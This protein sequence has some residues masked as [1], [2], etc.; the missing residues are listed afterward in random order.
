MK[1]IILLIILFGSFSANGQIVL[2]DSLYVFG[3]E[4]KKDC[5]IISTLSKVNDTIKIVSQKD[6]LLWKRKYEKICLNKKYYFDIEKIDVNKMAPVP[7]G[8]FAIKTKKTILW[9][10]NEKYRIEDIPYFENN[11]KGLYLRKK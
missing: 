9:I 11:L 1:N 7:P 4:E 8:H 3:I 6:K 10:N 2:K 5:Y